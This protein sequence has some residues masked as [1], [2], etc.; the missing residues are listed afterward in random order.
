MGTSVGELE[1][2][3]VGNLVGY[4]V[5][6]EVL[7]WFISYENE[8]NNICQCKTINCNV[9]IYVIHPFFSFVQYQYLFA[10]VSKVFFECMSNDR[11]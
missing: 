7:Y 1:G 6:I 8:Q 2:L 4:N 9:D 3:N 5:G 10:H 11:F